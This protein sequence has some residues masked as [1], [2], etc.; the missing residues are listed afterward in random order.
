VLGLHPGKFKTRF[1]KYSQSSQVVDK[2]GSSVSYASAVI[3]Y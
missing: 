3:Y 2:N 1:V